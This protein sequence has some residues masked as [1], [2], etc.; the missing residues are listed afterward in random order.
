MTSIRLTERADR[1][2]VLGVV[3]AAFGPED[4]AVGIVETVWRS[5]AHLP[6]LDLVA[7]EDGRIVG[8]VLHS[9][10]TVEDRKVVALA[11]LAVDAPHQRRGIGSALVTEALRRADEADHPMVVLLGHPDYYPRFGFERAMT[12]G[13]TYGD[14]P[15]PAEAFQARRLRAYDPTIRGRFRFAWELG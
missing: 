14:R 13:L 10:A 1:D 5:A 3:R 9:V 12:L 8:H 6:D 2:D 15:P 11:P 4:D 7:V